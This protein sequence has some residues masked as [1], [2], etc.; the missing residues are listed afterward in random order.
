MSFKI[1]D[2]NVY[3]KYTEIWNKT[4]KSLNARFHNQ[5]IYDDKY[6]KTK[7]NT[8]RSMIN[9][10]FSSDEIPRERNHYICIAAIYIL[11]CIESRQEK[12]SSSLL[13]TM[14]IQNKKKKASRFYSC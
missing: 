12:L 2:E 13:R 1:E 7:V 4:K 5:P 14:E 10:L 11:F 6:I 8:F 9:A 3:L